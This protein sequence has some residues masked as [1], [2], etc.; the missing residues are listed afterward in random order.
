[1]LEKKIEPNIRLFEMNHRFGSKISN[2][3]CK[4]KSYMVCNDSEIKSKP[5]SQKS[6]SLQ[7]ALT[8]K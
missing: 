7:K 5:N 6:S 3:Q 4:H 8:V 1:M 2:S